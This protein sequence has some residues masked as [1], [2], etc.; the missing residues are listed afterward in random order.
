MV[1]AWAM[2][3]D[4][5]IVM[6]MV[7]V[8]TLVRTLAI[9]MARVKDK[10]GGYVKN[11]TLVEKIILSI[12]N[13]TIGGFCLYILWNDCLTRLF[14]NLHQL[15]YLTASVMIFMSKGIKNCVF[16]NEIT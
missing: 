2:A 15:D 16:S 1:L 14:D 13:A 8:M 5:A 9:V 7:M 3:M 4:Q 10:R 6:L 11:R 12:L